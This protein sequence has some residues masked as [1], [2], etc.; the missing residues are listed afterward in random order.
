M[1]VNFPTLAPTSRNYTAGEFPTKRFN[2]ISGAGTTRLY[3]SKAYNVSLSL[4]FVLSDTDLASVLSCYDQAKGSAYGLT[5]PSTIFDGMSSDVQN[6]IPDHVTWRWDATPQVES[7]F[8]D[9]SRVRVSL[10]GTLDG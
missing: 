5:L 2:S 8:P 6:Q 1:T 7:L 10:L 3:G 9:R 4:E